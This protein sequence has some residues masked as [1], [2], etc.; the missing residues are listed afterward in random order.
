M[1]QEEDEVGYLC[2]HEDIMFWEYMS[3]IECHEIEK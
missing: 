3:E 1:L 2:E